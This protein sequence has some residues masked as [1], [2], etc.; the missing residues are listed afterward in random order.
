M[1][2]SLKVVGP[3]EMG[4]GAQKGRRHRPRAGLHVRTCARAGFSRP[5]R[6]PAVPGGVASSPRP[7]RGSI[8]GARGALPAPF[9]L[10]FSR[11]G[12]GVRGVSGHQGVLVEFL[13]DK[14][15]HVSFLA[16][17][18]SDGEPG[19]VLGEHLR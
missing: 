1:G 11:G 7:P 12:C 4:G 18:V 9:C 5:F 14:L 3:D 15:R 17:G 10:L 16:M 8:K 6:S 19:D 2:D 13:R